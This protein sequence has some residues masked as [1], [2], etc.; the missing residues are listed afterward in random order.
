VAPDDHVILLQSARRRGEL[1][2]IDDDHV[3]LGKRRAGQQHQAGE[4]GGQEAATAHL[5]VAARCSACIWCSP[6]RVSPDSS[7]AFGSAFSA[8]GIR[9]AS[10]ASFA[11]LWKATS[12]AT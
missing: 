9:V 1:H 8:E 7:R 3:F 6:N 11:V 5:N 2:G 10:R 12:L 4:Q